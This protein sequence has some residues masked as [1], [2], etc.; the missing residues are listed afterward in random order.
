[1]PQSSQSSQS[2]SSSSSSPASAWDTVAV[3]QGVAG[4]ERLRPGSPDDGLTETQN[5][6]GHGAIVARLRQAVRARTGGWW[7]GPRMV[8]RIY[9]L[10]Q[11]RPALK[12]DASLAATA[13][14]GS[15]DHSGRSAAQHYAVPI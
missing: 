7:V 14:H 15:V 5:V 11:V 4:I 10:Q 12:A 1:M 3:V 13:I 6:V 2:P 8:P 9:V